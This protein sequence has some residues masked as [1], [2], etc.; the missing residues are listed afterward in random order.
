MAGITGPAG[1]DQ[2]L[3]TQLA[4]IEPF[5]FNVIAIDELGRFAPSAALVGGL[6]IGLTAQGVDVRLLE[7]VRPFGAMANE[8]RVFM[9]ERIGGD[10]RALEADRMRGSFS[11]DH[12]ALRTRGWAFQLHYSALRGP[13][14]IPFDEGHSAGGAAKGKIPDP[15][16]TVIDA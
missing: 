8:H 2:V 4:R 14:S 9:C 3:P 10:G 16:I 7:G 15:Q 12:S 11:E 13:I 5:F 6:N 1:A